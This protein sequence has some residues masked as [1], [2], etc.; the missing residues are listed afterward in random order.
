MRSFRTTASAALATAASLSLAA[1]ETLGIATKTE[2]PTSVSAAEVLKGVPPVDNSPKSPCWQQQQIATQR[3][4]IDAA[5]SGKPK[6]Y[7][8]EC[9]EPK[10]GPAEKP[11]VKAEPKT[12]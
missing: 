10:K 9:L 11:P 2:A 6:Q 5:I 8:A 7:H 4:Y 3:A 12:S 1:C